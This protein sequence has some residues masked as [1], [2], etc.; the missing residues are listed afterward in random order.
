MKTG[1]ATVSFHVDTD[2]GS[3]FQGTYT[4]TNTGPTPLTNWRL[5]FTLPAQISSVWNATVESQANGVYRLAPASWAATL[6][7]NVPVTLGFVAAPGNLT[8]PPGGITL[9]SDTK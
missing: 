5:N 7:P 6:A 2:W 3:G 8:Q 4:L 1:G 9:T